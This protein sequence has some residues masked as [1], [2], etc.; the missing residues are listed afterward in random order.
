MSDP[1][2]T[3]ALREAALA[4]W[5]HN[6][7]RFRED[8]HAAHPASPASGAKIPTHSYHAHFGRK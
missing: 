4:A 2:R 5:T 7:D 1:L 6:P 3:A 8:A